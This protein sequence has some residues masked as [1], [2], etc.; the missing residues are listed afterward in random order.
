MRS[1]GVCQRKFPITQAGIEP[2]TFRFVAQ[3]FKHCATA[4][5]CFQLLSGRIS[6]TTLLRNTCIRKSST[7]D[8]EPGSKNVCTILVDT[9]LIEFIIQGQ[10]MHYSL[11]C[12]IYYE[13]AAKPLGV[14]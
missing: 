3:H 7:A 6:D 5:P 12:V 13:S 2:G 11:R 14:N 4:V 9:L 8:W 10:R 1:E